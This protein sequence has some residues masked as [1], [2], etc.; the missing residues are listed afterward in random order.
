MAQ[1][2]DCGRGFAPSDIGAMNI[3]LSGGHA[4]SRGNGHSCGLNISLVSEGLADTGHGTIA[5]H[6]AVG[7]TKDITRV[8]YLNRLNANV[9]QNSS[10]FPIEPLAF[11]LR[12]RL[13]PSNGWRLPSIIIRRLR[14]RYGNYLALAERS[15]GNRSREEPREHYF[16]PS[17][18]IRTISAKRPLSG[19]CDRYFF[20]FK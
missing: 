3:L 20:H 5:M 18:R 7:Y 1:Q 12:Y 6:K 15:T 8:K 16:V 4:A 2:R 19:E 14:R 9:A 17:E 13:F 10:R 11:F